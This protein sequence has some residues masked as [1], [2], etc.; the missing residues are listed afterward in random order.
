[1]DED[2]NKKK[3]YVIRIKKVL[4]QKSNEKEK[5]KKK[6]FLYIFNDL[7]TRNRIRETTFLLKPFSLW[8]I[9][10]H[11]LGYFIKSVPADTKYDIRYVFDNKTK[12]R[13]H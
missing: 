12:R 1:M 13:P 3:N 8:P 6:S 9:F 10:T 11:S 4:Y 5:D 7:L 2:E